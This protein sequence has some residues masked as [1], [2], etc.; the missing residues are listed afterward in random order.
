MKKAH[1][2]ETQQLVEITDDLALGK[3]YF[4][5]SYSKACK[6]AVKPET[7][8]K[9]WEWLGMCPIS[10]AKPLYNPMFIQQQQKPETNA[11]HT[12]IAK[13]KMF[14]T[15]QNMILIAYSVG[16]VS[17]SPHPIKDIP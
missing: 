2:K 10:M 4:L 1:R 13:R 15:I 9:S 16:N 3:A 8:L 7:I 11:S 17:V 12:P 5:K 6:H 14:N